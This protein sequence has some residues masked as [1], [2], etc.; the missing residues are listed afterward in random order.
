MVLLGDRK[1]YARIYSN[2]IKNTLN[3]GVDS[4]SIKV[5]MTELAIRISF[6]NI[7]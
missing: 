2:P 1:I 5:E 6:S 4:C 7:N 3:H